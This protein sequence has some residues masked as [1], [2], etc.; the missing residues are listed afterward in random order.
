ME[1]WQKDLIGMIEAVTDGV[2]QFFLEI[3][4][5]VEAF[6]EITEEITE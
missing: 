6:F 1:Q 2:E 4:D 3:N 5:M